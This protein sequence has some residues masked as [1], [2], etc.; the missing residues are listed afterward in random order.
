MFQNFSYLC[1]GLGK[2]HLFFEGGLRPSFLF[3]SPL[4]CLQP[5]KWRGMTDF[6][7]LFVGREVTLLRGKIMANTPHFFCPVLTQNF[8]MDYEQNF[9]RSVML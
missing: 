7:S 9:S 2:N 4:L 1:I 3:Y 6:P 8:T 5:V